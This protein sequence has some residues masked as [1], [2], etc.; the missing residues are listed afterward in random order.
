MDEAPTAVLT[1]VRWSRAD[2]LWM[3]IPMP[4]S[5]AEDLAWS[6]VQLAGDDGLA[7]VT[8]RSL[9]RH[10]R[11]SPGT[12][13]N[14]F[15][16]KQE[17]LAICTSVVGKWLASATSDHVDDRGAV[18]LFPTQHDHDQTYR[19]LVSTWAQLCAHGLTDRDVDERVQGMTPLLNSGAS[20]A[21]PGEDHQFTVGAWL[22]LDGLRR[23]LVRRAITLT[24]D[25]A[26]AAFQLVEPA[27]RRAPLTY[28][29]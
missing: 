12:I 18:G 9:A 4:K 19:L 3:G 22:C 5:L 28:E 16:S 6:L 24:A 26:L 2:S 17:L 25:D 21:C 13:S 27:A 1:V 8:M 23:E 10:T 7:N 11:V 14:R 20:R 29:G 15:A